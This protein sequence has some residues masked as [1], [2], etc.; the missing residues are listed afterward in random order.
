[1][2]IQ[3]CRENGGCLQRRRIGGSYDQ[4][5][6][7]RKD[8]FS[9]KTRTFR[10]GVIPV[11]PMR[12][13]LGALALGMVAICYGSHSNAQVV[14]YQQLRV[15]LIAPPGQQTVVHAGAHMT[16][17][18][19][20]ITGNGSAAP[21]AGHGYYGVVYGGAWSLARKADGHPRKGDTYGGREILQLGAEVGSA[22]NKYKWL[23]LKYNLPNIS[24]DKE[25]HFEDRGRTITYLT[26]PSPY[27]FALPR[28]THGQPFLA[29]ELYRTGETRML[30]RVYVKAKRME[31]PT[32]GGGCVVAGD[33]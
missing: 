26:S 7:K 33:Q 28:C 27:R 29:C 5:D 18:F 3:T 14:D 13:G 23:L 21:P 20:I 15:K 16:G 6:V 22:P 9:R 17:E 8:E 4:A 19:G 31:G 32:D 24:F 11:N 25:S 2:E 30:T 12:K 1:M 10:L